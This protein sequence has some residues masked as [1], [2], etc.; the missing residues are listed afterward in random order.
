MLQELAQQ[1]MHGQQLSNRHLMTGYQQAGQISTID[2]RC[3]CKHTDS[4]TQPQS[5]RKTSVYSPCLTPD[6]T[7]ST[8]LLCPLLG[9]R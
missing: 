4:C 8:C 1:I 6:L 7:E 3:L 9:A 2:I 5:M